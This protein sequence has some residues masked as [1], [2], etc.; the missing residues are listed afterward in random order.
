MRKLIIAGAAL[1]SLALAGAA[2]AMPV[3]V[4]TTDGAEGCAVL[5]GAGGGT[6]TYAPTSAGG[7]VAQG[8]YTIT[9]TQQTIVNGVT[10]TTTTALPAGSKEGC[11]QWAPG[12]DAT[13]TPY[14]NTISVTL[15]V[16]DNQSGGA[17]GDP[18]PAQT[19]AAGSGGT[20][21]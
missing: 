5:S 13:A 19:Q 14:P 21:C 10:T 9:V 16:A 20:A 7:F 2:G 1:T 17:I 12:G 15:S 6:C 18:F 8:N 4:P 3:P 11:A